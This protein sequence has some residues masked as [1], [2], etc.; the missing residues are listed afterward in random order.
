MLRLGCAM[1]EVQVA[2]AAYVARRWEWFHR[3]TLL[4]KVTHVIAGE[5]GVS[6]LC[7]PVHT[8]K[9]SLP[10]LR[11]SGCWWC[12]PWLD[13]LEALH[14]DGSPGKLHLDNTVPALWAH[15]VLGPWAVAKM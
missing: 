3:H 11:A 6:G 12:V 8:T 13:E 1:V 10:A 2:L 4:P 7:C 5:H 14:V 15:P 9:V